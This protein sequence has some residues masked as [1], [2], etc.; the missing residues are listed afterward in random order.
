MRR[1]LTLVACLLLP[2]GALAQ[3]ADNA[4][5]EDRGFIAGLLERALGGDGRI[6]RIVGFAGAL[7]S[8]ATIDEITIADGDGIWLTLDDV[9]MTWNRRALLRGT[10]DI[11]ELRAARIDLPRLPVTEPGIDVPNAEA[12]P[13]ALPDLPAAIVI[14]QLDIATL[15]L[16]APVLGET[17]DLSLS[18][19]A[20]L[21]GGAGDVTLIAQR[22]DGSQA[23]F[24]LAASYANDTRALGIDLDI[25]E[26]AGGLIS[27]L[28]D[29]PGRP[30]VSL[31]VAGDGL[32][33]DFAATLDLRTDGAPRLLGTL[34]LQSEA[35]GPM[36]FDVDV[37]GDVTALFLPQYA[38]FFGPDVSLNAQGNQ[39]SDGALQLDSFALDTRALR[40]GGQ[41]AL[42]RDGWPT[43]L[44]ITG[45]VSDPNGDA[46]LLPAGGEETR[47]DAAD[48]TVSFD[49]SDSNALTA[50]I[51]IA[52]LDRSDVKAGAVTMNMDGTLS[53]D[54][55]AIGALQV[56]VDLDASDLG[57]ADPALAGAVG[58]V[59]RGG[60]DVGYGDDAP[61]RLGNL[62]L[63]GAA[64][65]LGGNVVIQSL[66]QD[67]ATTFDVALNTPDLSAFADLAGLAL[68]GAGSISASG[69][70]ALGGFFDVELNG[71]TQDLALGIE[72][73]DAVLAGTTNVGLSARRDETGT[74][75]DALTL[76]NAALA[77]DVSAQLQSGASDARFDIRLNDASQ[78][79]PE[80]SGPLTVNG[81]A[82][83]TGEDWD[84]SAALAGPL[85]ATAN[86]DAQITGGDV[87]IDLSAAVPDLQPLVPA[88]SGG[89]TISAKAVQSDGAWDFD[90]TLQGPFD[91]AATAS[92][93]FA[94]G[95]L[96]T[97]YTAFLPSLDPFVP[98]IPG[99]VSLTGTVQ[100]VPQGWEFDTNV[101]GPYASSAR[102][103]GQ[104]LDGVL[105]ADYTANLPNISDVA[106]GVPGAASVRGN[107]Q[108]VPEGWEFTT[109][110]SGP[111]DSTGNVSGSYKAARLA[112]AFQVAV[113]NLSS[114]APGVSGA[115]EVDG[116]LAQLDDGWSVETEISGP[117]N[118]TGTVDGTFGGAGTIA[119]YALQMPEVGALVPQMSGAAAIT[120]TATQGPRGFDIDAAFQGPSGTTANVQG[121]V[122][123][124]GQ[125]A[126][127][128]RGQAQL[129]LINPFIAPRSITGP[130]SFDLTVDGPPEL[131]SVQGQITTQGTRIAMPNLPLSFSDLSGAVSLSRGQAQLDLNG[132]VTEGGAIRISGPIALSG[133]FAGQLAV[134]LNSVVVT[135]NVLYNSILDGDIS[136]NGPLTGGARI[137]GTVNV[138]ET[139]VLVPAST[140]ST[141]GTIP[142]ITHIG[143]T[144]P[145]MQTRDRAGLIKQETTPT[146]TG[147][148]TPYP[149]D[150]T[151]NV[152][153]RIF[154]RGR[155]LDAEL[156]G[157]LRIEGTSDNTVSTGEIE[158]I[159]GR[160]NVLSKRFDL[161]VGRVQFQGRFVP[162]IRFL[163]TTPIENGTATITV[164]GPADDPEVI[165]S[166]TPEAPQDQVLAQIFFGRDIS[167]LTAF[168]ALQLASAV[169]T[170]AG[171]GGETL[172][173]RLRGSIGVD[174]LDVVADEEGNA[175]LRAGKY[176]SDNVY[177]D[178]TVGGKDGPELSLNIDLT[179]TVTVRGTVASDNS[180][181]IG[182]FVEKDY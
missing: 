33:S 145:S 96:S 159:R 21:A 140:V 51:R 5:D 68:D 135:D 173:S 105:R 24:N 121:L 88:I 40:L 177:T 166:A 157:S 6:V 150:I 26:A 143:E 36:A 122:G 125:L 9:A 42:N 116:T 20:S 170:L 64:W 174:D 91:S 90:T 16:G 117:Y 178:I 43:L 95:V 39:D 156:G 12:S 107:V 113:P 127:D 47:I 109:N 160:L 18:G 165:F 103:R 23:N 19:M 81:T 35:D 38:E 110:L 111:Y 56:R 167:Q 50:A 172:M 151:V 169:A 82:L 8:T 1:I 138:G 124:D 126:L 114:L 76:N 63:R 136:V 73:A 48:L 46:V 148:S 59:V 27:G 181:G 162:Y 30:S 144:R 182:I 104:F 129:G 112:T 31:K 137:A 41:A 155:G 101:S 161:D 87:N 149:L 93:R 3:D 52:G 108:Q 84:M 13:F 133:D 120:G 34:A 98:D 74:F 106:P 78:V 75:L 15:A 154:V 67:F 163:A 119:R 164:E 141:L 179:P 153:S 99:A 72:Q 70:A 80:L 171:N 58:A 4:E 37:N 85:D 55:N 123:A 11:Q 92:G 32:L 61:L 89:A 139:N 175:E 2:L 146:S 28:M 17:A 176:L 57:F 168:Q 79:V 66:S 86:V 142:E 22:I 14:A 94:D 60:L 102:T 53:G 45:Q 54:V 158:L 10:I 180:T 130:V 97:T 65:D 131:G 69:T 152:P 118:S 100:Q 132:Q 83:Q 77:A 62:S 71:T 29:L 134:A 25:S 44:D 115:L 128:A 49:A 7:S 147:T